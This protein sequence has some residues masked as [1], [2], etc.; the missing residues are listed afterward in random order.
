[1][2][3]CYRLILHCY[4]LTLRCYPSTL[5]HNGVTLHD[6]AKLN[7]SVLPRSLATNEIALFKKTKRNTLT[8]R[9]KTFFYIKT[10][11][12]HMLR[13]LSPN[14]WRKKASELFHTLHIAQTSPQTT[15]GYFQK[16]KKN[17]AYSEVWVELACDWR[18]AGYYLSSKSGRNGGS[19]VLQWRGVILKRTIEITTNK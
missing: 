14:F 15:S 13:T 7:S 1:M 8:K 11:L 9:L 19:S 16:L 12:T 3:W 17:L 18:C 6:C 4:T 2:G 5:V 10:M